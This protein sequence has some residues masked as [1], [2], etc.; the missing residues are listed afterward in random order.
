MYF[1]FINLQCSIFV[2]LLNKTQHAYRRGHSTQ[3]CLSELANY[4]YKEIDNGNIVGIASLDPSK[5][6][7][8]ICHSHLLQKL[9]TLQLGQNSLNWVSSYLT[10]RKQKTKFKKFTST[11]ETVTSGVPQGCSLLGVSF[12][13]VM[14]PLLDNI[15]L[16]CFYYIM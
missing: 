1:L 16:H 7:D 2:N 11:C 6:F 13:T 5:A 14:L 15:I 3:T 9:S 8:S 4:V 10:D 12:D